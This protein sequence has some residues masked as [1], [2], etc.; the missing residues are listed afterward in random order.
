MF[1]CVK[2]K[3]VLCTYRDHSSDSDITPLKIIYGYTA[4]SNYERA[5]KESSKGYTDV[6]IVEELLEGRK[7]FQKQEEEKTAGLNTNLFNVPP[8][9]N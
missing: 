3:K 9:R 1:W 7:E 8:Q 2:H 4:I 6:I 5:H